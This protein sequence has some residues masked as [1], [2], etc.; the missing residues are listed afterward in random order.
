M[1]KNRDKSN[2]LIRSGFSLVEIIIVI[3]I[4]AILIGVIALAVL[5]NI[6]RSRESKDLTKLDNILASTNIAIANNQIGEA[7]KFEIGGSTPPEA[8]SVSKK[9]YDAVEEE[10]GDLTNI[11]LESSAAVGHG[12]IKVGWIV[13]N[14]SAPH[15]VVQLGD[16]NVACQYTTGDPSDSSGNRLFKVEAGSGADPFV[17]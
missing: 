6:Q 9:I 13:T 7:G 11:T 14:P 2:V 8:G 1:D 15:I 12:N 10:L 16:G 5:P 17:P 3:A 4:M